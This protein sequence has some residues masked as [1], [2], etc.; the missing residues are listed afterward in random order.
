[1]R[2]FKGLGTKALATA[3]TLTLA[4][5]AGGLAGPAE[6]KPVTLLEG[7]ITKLKYVNYEDWLDINVPGGDGV[8]NA[9][10]KFEG[11]LKVESITNV[12]GSVSLSAQ[13]GAK[14]V[15]GS[16]RISVVGGAIVPG[17]SG[18]VDLALVPGDFFRFF[19]GTG[20]TKNWDPAAGD[21]VARA[22]DGVLWADILPGTFFEGVNDTIIFPFSFSLSKNWADITTNL[23]EYT[24]VPLLYPEVIPLPGAAPH[25]FLGVPHFAGHV[26]DTFFTSHLTFPSDI[27]AWDIKSE[28][29]LY[30][31]AVVPEP[32]TL[33]LLGAGLFGAGLIARRRSRK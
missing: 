27:P 11:I 5:T 19:V 9:G 1:M 22:T 33:L 29:P 6:A 18:H 10:D 24:I 30:V 15:T 13:L 21:A 14:E 32:A 28:D 2:K 23:T 31:F 8:I 4:L 20:A 7:A 25:T 12:S 26:A 16:F 17:G 3:V